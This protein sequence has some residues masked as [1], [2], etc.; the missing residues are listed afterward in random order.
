MTGARITAVTIA[1]S[2]TLYTKVGIAIWR[3]F[4]VGLIVALVSVHD[5]SVTFAI[6][7]SGQ[8]SR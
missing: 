8:D 4:S 2:N 1:P 6:H 7:I 3:C 5:V